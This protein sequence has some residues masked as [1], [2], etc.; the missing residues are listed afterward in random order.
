LR[1]CAR[2]SDA[3]K[4]DI[5]QTGEGGAGFS[6]TSSIARQSVETIAVALFFLL[7][8]VVSGAFARMSPVPLP[9]PLVQIALGSIIAPWPIS[10]LH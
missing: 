1:K 5:R 9:L 3:R 8:V 7:A 6:A 10:A 4:A 2:I